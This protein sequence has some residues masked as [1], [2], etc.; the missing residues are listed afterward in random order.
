MKLTLVGGGGFRV[1]Q[2]LSV[3]D[4]HDD[5]KISEVCLYDVD[6]SR[7]AVMSAVAEQMGFANKISQI[8]TT[9]S[10]DEAVNGADFVFSAMRVSG[11]CGRVHDEREA[12]RRG[13][14]GQETVGVAGYAYA[15]RTIPEA[16]RLAR[17]VADAAP[18]AWVI[19]FTNPAGII[20]Q[21]MRT[22]HPRVVGICDTPIGLVR[23][24]AYLIGGEELMDEVSG[25]DSERVEYD[26][27]G[28][29][30]LGW[31]RTLVVDGVDRLPEIIGDDAQL[32]RMEEARTIGKDWI[33]AIGA[34]PN[35]YLYYYYHNREIV[36]KLANGRTRG[37]FLREQQG[38]FYEGALAEPE[39]AAQLWTATHNEREAT[40]MAEAR[41]EGEE[42]TVE[43]RMSGG[44]E[45]VARDLMAALA[46]G[47]P[48][49]MILGVANSDGEDGLLIPQ[50]RK[51]AVIEVPCRVDARGIHPQKPGPLSGPELGLM[52]L[53]KA[54][55]ELVV[56]AGLNGDQVDAWRA[57]ASHPLVDSI[58]VARD[59]LKAYI[60]VNPDIAR[61][62]GE[63]DGE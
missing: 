58:E 36:A 9:I 32:I 45:H 14:L 13:L 31:L 19:N 48:A 18:E 59:V 50:L 4:S 23:R 49:R 35:E 24:A 61:T 43:D 22:V 34:I 21:A 25:A 51:D 27:A 53:V 30:H 3:I 1:P 63:P 33:R 47:K 52:Q 29:N 57:L 38:A 55:E 8:S 56:D 5:L 15:F 2:V 62:F 40:Y 6:E 54:C 11:A 16:M 44:Y 7:L 12:L 28:L 17:A 10:L 42:R 46:T 39:R 41:A 60:E 37:E 20:T 26:Y